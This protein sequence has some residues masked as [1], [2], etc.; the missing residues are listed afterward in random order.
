MKR[1]IVALMTLLAVAAA[2]ATAD[3]QTTKAR[4][5]LGGFNLFSVTH[6]IQ[7]GQQSAVAAEKQM[8]LLGVPGADRYINLIAQRLTPFAPGARYPYAAKIVN[9]PDIKAFSLPGG[10]LY[11]NRGL[12]D[13]TRNEAELASV[14]AHE[15][16][17]VALR[18]GTTIVSNAYLGKTGLGLLGG[19][20]G[21]RGS[22]AS[23]IVNVVGGMGLNA[24]FLKFSRDD[25]NNAD[26][27]GAEM[28]ARAGY[29]P[30]AMADFFALLRQKNG[31][32]PSTL[33]MFFGSH[34]PGR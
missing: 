8:A 33:E 3:A 22:T 24:T 23:N 27:V 29:S 16:A 30:V 19:L 10:P 6:D 7:I 21:K 20:V 13:A 9:A 32:D 18:H 4:T 31:R 15:M 26:R 34:P 17:H 14:I 12:I 25:E 11:L 5:A 1:Y 28:M 2:Y